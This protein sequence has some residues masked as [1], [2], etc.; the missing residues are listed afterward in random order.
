MSK[1][2]HSFKPGESGNPNGRPKGSVSPLRKQLLELRKRAANDI[3]EA[4]TMLWKDFKAGD[5]L[6]KQIYF[7]ELVSMPKEWLNEIDTKD[8]PKVIKN[9]EDVTNCT[10]KLIEKLVNVDNMSTQEALD[11]IKTLKN[12]NISEEERI[13]HPSTR[14]ELLEKKALLEDII[15]KRKSLGVITLEEIDSPRR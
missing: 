5:P 15:E 7:K 13:Y 12:N 9:T 1:T 8:M 11:L 4:Y 14:E 3:E 2:K 6:A 10:L